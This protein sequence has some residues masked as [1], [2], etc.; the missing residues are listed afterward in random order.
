MVW[1]VVPVDDDT[2]VKEAPTP[3]LRGD[4]D[5]AL[6]AQE[7][8]VGMTDEDKITWGIEMILAVNDP[9][10]HH[11]VSAAGDIVGRYGHDL[12][13]DRLARRPDG[14]LIHPYAP[15]GGPLGETR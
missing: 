15:D 12:A 11:R 3:P 14:S 13:R 7:F 5:T 2:P 8:A 4:M 1:P 6:M 10:Q 9:E